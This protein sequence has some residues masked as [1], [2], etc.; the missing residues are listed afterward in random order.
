MDSRMMS[1]NNYNAE[2]AYLKFHA[3][4]EELKDVW[5]S[6]HK[7]LI[8]YQEREDEIRKKN[9]E[10]NEINDSKDKFFSIIAHDLRSPFQGLLGIS[11]IFVAPRE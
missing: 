7:L 3:E 6:Y 4:V 10:L 5:E 2:K 9:E 1:D 11:K 8:S